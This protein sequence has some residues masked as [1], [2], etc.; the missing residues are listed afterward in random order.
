L[1]RG[2]SMFTEILHAND[3]SDCALEALFVDGQSGTCRG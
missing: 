3:G 2:Q 1:K